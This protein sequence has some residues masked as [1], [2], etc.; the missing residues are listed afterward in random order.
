VAVNN[1]PE[2][3]VARLDERVKHLELDMCD[4]KET[5][6]DTNDKVDAM[7]TRLLAAAIGLATAA[8][9]LTINLITGSLVP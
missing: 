3:R 5:V 7:S 2:A 4:L 6:R 9:M 8:V 1:G